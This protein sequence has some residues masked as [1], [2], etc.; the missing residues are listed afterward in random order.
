MRVAFKRSRDKIRAPMK[1]VPWMRFTWDLGKLPPPEKAVSID[2]VAY[3]I[4]PARRDEEKVVHKV[5][6]SAFSLDMDW[7]DT[8]KTMAGWLESQIDETFSHRGVPCL[9]VSHGS[10]II[11]VS[12]FDPDSEAESNLVTGPSILNEYHN[13]GIGTALLYQTLCTLRDAGL[14]KAHAATKTNVPAAKFVYTKFNSVSEPW[15]FSPA[16]TGS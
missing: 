7:A 15:E 6:F 1:L 5:L 10:R 8:L 9:V 14:K 16:P 13:R 12:L 11:G 2:P 3:P 4:R